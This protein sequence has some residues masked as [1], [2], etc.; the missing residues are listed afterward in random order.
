MLH[1]NKTLGLPCSSQDAA[2]QK[3]L[4]KLRDDV[5]ALERAL[6]AAEESGTK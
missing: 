1:R 2:I 4:Q 6:A 5:S 3:N